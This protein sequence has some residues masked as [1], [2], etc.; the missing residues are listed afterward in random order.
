MRRLELIY[1]CK[2][3]LAREVALET[4]STFLSFLADKVDFLSWKTKDL[5]EFYDNFEE[6]NG[7]KK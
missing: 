7:G 1:H 4:N 3:I 5:Q 6:G 2:D